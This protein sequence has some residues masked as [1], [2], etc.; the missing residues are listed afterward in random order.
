MNSERRKHSRFLLNGVSATL[1]LCYPPEEIQIPGEIIDISCSG[2][3]IQLSQPILQNLDGR[4]INIQLTMPESGI[5]LTIK[6]LIKHHLSPTEYGL[7]YGT[8]I[9]EELMDEFIF[10]C[11]KSHGRITPPSPQYNH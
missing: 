5:P 3:K 9:A 2:I 7:H 8:P 4:N 11:T 1:T 10:E 6:G